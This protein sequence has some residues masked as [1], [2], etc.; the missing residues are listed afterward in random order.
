MVCWVEFPKGLGICTG[1]L[2]SWIYWVG[3]VGSVSWME[4]FLQGQ[5]CWG[6]FAGSDFLAQ[7]VWVRLAG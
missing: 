2:L 7:V 4:F 3:W 5:V 1:G 6:M